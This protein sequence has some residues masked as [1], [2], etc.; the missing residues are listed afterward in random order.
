MKEKITVTTV[1]AKGLILLAGL[2]IL[3]ACTTT[4]TDFTDPSGPETFTDERPLVAFNR[5]MSETM[6]L[7]KDALERGKGD[8][9]PKA[10][11]LSRQGGVRPVQIAGTSARDDDARLQLLF[12]SLEIMTAGDQ[13]VAFVVYAVGS[14]RLVNTPRRDQVLIAHLEHQSGK[15]V[16]RRISYTRD[17][18]EVRFG[19]EDIDG[20][21]PLIFTD[22]STE[23]Q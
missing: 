21:Q 17:G 22:D 14:G 9:T 7:A 8:F 16:L 18:D 10:F 12:D 23:S 3:A 15:A 5:L 2:G 1:F 11:A 19:A 6:P 4:Y 20:T 13:I